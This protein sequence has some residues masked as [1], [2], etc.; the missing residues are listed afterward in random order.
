VLSITLGVGFG[1]TFALGHTGMGLCPYELR[2]QTGDDSSNDFLVWGG[3]LLNITPAIYA[4]AT[5]NRFFVEH[6]ESEHGPKVGVVF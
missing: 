5:V 3:A 1:I 2:I 4:G 6:A